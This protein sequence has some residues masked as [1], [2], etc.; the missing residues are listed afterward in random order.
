MF[1]L[2]PVRARNTEGTPNHIRVLSN[3]DACHGTRNSKIRYFET[4][5]RRD[6]HVMRF[7]VAMDKSGAMGI[8]NSSAGLDHQRNALIDR[9]A[10]ALTKQG[11]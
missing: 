8:T 7:D 2:P 3:A 1:L 10:A 6:Q 11:L 5:I 9:E 4:I